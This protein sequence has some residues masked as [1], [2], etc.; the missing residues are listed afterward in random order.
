MRANSVGI[1]DATDEHGITPTFRTPWLITNRYNMYDTRFTFAPFSAPTRTPRNFPS[2]S[3]SPSSSSFSILSS[4]P[5]SSL[6]R[7]RSCS[8]SS[9]SR[10]FFLAS[11]CSRILFSS[12]SCCIFSFTCSAWNSSFSIS[13]IS[14]SVF[15]FLSISTL[16][17]SS[18]FSTD[19][20]LSPINAPP[21]A[22]LTS[23]IS[24]RLSLILLP[25][26]TSAS[27]FA[28]SAAWFFIT[29][30]PNLAT[31]HNSVASTHINAS[32][33][34][35]FRRALFTRRSSCF[36]GVPLSRSSSSVFI[37]RVSL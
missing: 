32:H 5:S 4:P 37:K 14:F 8:F 27:L 2:C 36:D 21:S 19:T 26:I 15:A 28:L 10:A 31:S 9:S 33:R 12:I 25:R 34:S 22:P 18:I 17:L 24:N 13:N 20:G 23:S 29:T 1:H 11:A 7:F 6:L 16:L 35:F 30:N 3:S